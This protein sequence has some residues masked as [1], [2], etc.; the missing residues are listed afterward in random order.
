MPPTTSSHNRF[1]NW[2]DT[3]SHEDAVELNAIQ[4]RLKRGKSDK[5]A[6]LEAV[7]EGREGREKFGSNRGKKLDEKPHSTTNKEKARKK[8]FLMTLRKHKAGQKMKLTEKRRLLKES[9]GKAQGK[10][11]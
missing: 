8:N 1:A 3:N 10:K 9:K 6:R 4:G 7:M 5:S 2:R 11:R